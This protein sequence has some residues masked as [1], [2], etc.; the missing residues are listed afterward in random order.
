[1][2]KYKTKITY[3]SIDLDMLPF[4]FLIHTKK[5]YYIEY[6]DIF[7]SN[8]LMYQSEMWIPELRERYNK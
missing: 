6:I 8:I 1:M 5:R 2:K 7:R 4:G 3:Y